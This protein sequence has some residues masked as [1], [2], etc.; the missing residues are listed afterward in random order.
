M[1]RALAIIGCCTIFI[2]PARSMDTVAPHLSLSLSQVVDAVFQNSDEWQ[3]ASLLAD[4]AEDRARSQRG[5]MFPKL[6]LEGSYRHLSEVP[7]L[8]FPGGQKIQLTDNKSYSIGPELRYSVFKGGSDYYSWKS[9]QANARSLRLQENVIRRQ[10]RMAAELAF[11]QTQLAAEQVRLLVESYKVEWEQY[12]DI[13]TRFEAG[14]AAKVDLLSARQQTLTRQRQLLNARAALAVALR[15]VT[16]LSGLGQNIEP[17]LP[18]D[19]RTLRPLPENVQEGSVILNIAAPSSTVEDATPLLEAAFDQSH[20]TVGS[21]LEMVQASKW[22]AKSLERGRW[23]ELTLLGRISRDYPNG[24]IQET[25]TQKT[26]GG[27]LSFPLFTGGALYYNAKSKQTEAEAKDHERSQA[28]KDLLA[29]YLKARDQAWILREER[30]LNAAT[31]HDTEELAK[32][33]YES[34][35]AGRA[36]YLDVEDANLRVLEAKTEAA[37]TDVRLL[38]QLAT[39]ES[40]SDVSPDRIGLAQHP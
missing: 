11:F 36:R 9:V 31:I 14:S 3:K 10:Q 1:R 19:G 38:I 5:S 24:P 30:A 22:A 8:S 23:P 15:E 21:L 37:N 28:A 6:S 39:L 12:R 17:K 26:I 4:A 40:L 27:N 7:T 20:P 29:T 35:K 34:Y 2:S 13:K 25:I 33:Q 32:L 18:L 16:R